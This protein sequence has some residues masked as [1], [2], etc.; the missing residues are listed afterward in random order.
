M[1]LIIIK[2]SFFLFS[3]DCPD[4]GIGGLASTG[5]TGF[6]TRKFG[7]MI[8]LVKSYEIVTASG[9]AIN[10]SSKENIDLFHA[11]RGSGG[12]SFGIITHVTLK[13]EKLDPYYGFIRIVVAK[14]SLAEWLQLYLSLAHDMNEDLMYFYSYLQKENIVIQGGITGN[15]F[16]S[17]N[18]GSSVVSY[19][20]EQ[21]KMRG[22]N[23]VSQNLYQIVY[24][25]FYKFTYGA[26]AL[27]K[28]T[29]FKST[30]DR[31]FRT[32]PNNDHLG[33]M[34][35]YICGDHIPIEAL[36]ELEDHYIRYPDLENADFSVNIELFGGK[37]FPDESY[38]VY[39][40]KGCRAIITSYPGRN[41]EKR[42]MIL[43]YQKEFWNILRPY[44]NYSYRGYED[45]S[46]GQANS[47]NGQKTMMK[48]HFG[49]NMEK[50]MQ[51]KSKYD[52]RNLFK[53]HMSIPTLECY[54]SGNCS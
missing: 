11:L 16:N 22:I 34:S 52:P 53:H 20:V 47:S 3:G 43:E 50:V 8:N 33:I 17:P 4:V 48:F 13:V 35:G 51:I 2:L 38:G 37:T 25:N 31:D 21:A 46:K 10:A 28:A 54:K 19:I 41:E 44:T 18:R 30:K 12:S 14:S 15:A 29:G 9:K 40:G 5:G 36:D 6:T 42:D 7:L 1:A 45:L 24:E 39:G 26:D 49:E 27:P 32:Q 23:I